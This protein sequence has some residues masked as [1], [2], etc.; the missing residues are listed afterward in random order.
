MT[1]KYLKNIEVNLNNILILTEDFNI[2]NNNWD[3]SYSYYS[4]HTDTLREVAD[5][6]NLELS[7][8]IKVPTVR[9][10]KNGLCFISY[11]YFL[12]NLF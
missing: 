6:F 9:A 4:T 1:L 10:T 3:L 8:S 12:F 7:I 5:I 2:S 11:C